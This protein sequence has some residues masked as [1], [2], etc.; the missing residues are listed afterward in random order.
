MT[1]IYKYLYTPRLLPVLVNV[2]WVLAG[3]FTMQYARAGYSYSTDGSEVTDST[4][5][6]IWRRCAEGMAW[7]GTNCMGTAVTYTHENAFIRAKT[8]ASSSG[9]AWRV[10]NVKELSSLHKLPFNSSIAIDLEAFPSTPTSA[11]YWTSTPNASNSVW[12]YFVNFYNGF[13]AAYNLRS[14]N[15][16]VRLVR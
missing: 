10:P 7:S 6:L 12:A 13:D 2:V 4:T 8:E 9:K 15:Y 14:Y 1:I 16:Y 3:M 5:G 11:Y